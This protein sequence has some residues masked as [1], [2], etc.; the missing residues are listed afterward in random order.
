MS[1]GRALRGDCAANAHPPGLVLNYRGGEDLVD[2]VERLSS[3]CRRSTSPPSAC[4]PRAGS[5]DQRGHSSRPSGSTL[6]ASRRSQG[7]RR[8]RRFATTPPLVGRY[9]LIGGPTPLTPVSKRARKSP[10]KFLHLT[11]QCHQVFRNFIHPVTIH[12]SPIRQRYAVTLL[13]SF[14][15]RP[16]HR[17][18]SYNLHS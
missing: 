3:A 11:Q 15:H 18:A 4:P 8:A 7:R 2:V 14:P 10:A 1:R 9:L 13:Q 5:P 12:Y 16:Q 17:L 6:T